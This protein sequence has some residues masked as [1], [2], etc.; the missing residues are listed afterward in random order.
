MVFGC[1]YAIWTNFIP[2]ERWGFISIII[3][4]MFAVFYS[5]LSLL[6]KTDN[7]NKYKKS[8][9]FILVFVSCYFIFFYN[10]SYSIP[11]IITEFSI[12]E[13][14]TE[15]KV[16]EKRER[17]LPLFADP[18][19]P[20]NIHISEYNK[21]SNINKVCLSY[22]E[23]VRINVDDVISIIG[24]ESWFGRKIKEIKQ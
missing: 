10:F 1:I 9:I 12:N 15:Y 3:G 18:D 24:K 19:C 7:L 11:S 6:V 16:L 5:T 14:N 21:D 2:N 22:A 23:V 17:K 8:S 20:Y 4:L 13:F